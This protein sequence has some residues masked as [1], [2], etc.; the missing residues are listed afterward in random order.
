ML[1]E[2][3][4]W[5]IATLVWYILFLSLLRPFPGEFHLVVYMVRN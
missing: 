3:S 1:F 4:K 2:W 5:I